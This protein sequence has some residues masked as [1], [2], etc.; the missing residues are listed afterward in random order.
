MRRTNILK[1]VPDE[2]QEAKLFALCT[3]SSVLWN[4]ITFKRRQ[5]F[6]DGTLDWDTTE[7]YQDFSPQIGSATTQQIIRKNNEAWKSFFALL[8]KKK[9]G[10]LSPHIKVIRPP[11]YWKDRK[12]GKRILRSLIRT[13]CYKF[14][15][16]RLLLPNK[17]AITYH[18]NLNWHGKQGRLEIHFDMLSKGWYAY[19]PVECTPLHQP[20]GNKKA[21]IDLGVINVLTTYTEGDTRAKLYSGKSLLSD[22]W[23]WNKQIANY[24]RKLGGKPRPTKKLNKLYRTR[25]RRFRQGI[26]T[27]IYRFVKDCYEKGVSEISVGDLTHIRVDNDK[28]K[29]TNAMIHNFW[30]F[31]Y[32]VDRLNITAENFG[33]IVKTIDESW[34]S[35]TCSLCGKRHRN[36]RKH[37]GL[38]V[39]KTA[40]KVLNADVNGVANLSNP[41]FPGPRMVER[42]NWVMAHPEVVRI[43]G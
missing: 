40:N 37:R 35:Q 43:R 25:K 36:G 20:L 39:C 11:G 17:L 3:L 15:A 18:G 8:R 33:M 22:W 21:Y 26:N 16:R 34:T 31:R 14:E 42:D 28:G 23:Y 5:S 13:D 2:D 6:F 24:Q 9:Q 1:L 32:I 38:Y 29:K 27:M 30:S 19:Q 7:E 41:I 4:K 12:T 10:K